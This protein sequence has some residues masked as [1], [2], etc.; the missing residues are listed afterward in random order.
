MTSE[1]AGGSGDARVFPLRAAEAPTEAQL[2][3][4]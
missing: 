2:G 3:G 4:H 1:P